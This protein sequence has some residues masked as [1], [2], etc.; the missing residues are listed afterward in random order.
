MLLSGA[1]VDLA[2][3][4]RLFVTGHDIEVKCRKAQEVEVCEVLEVQELE[5][6]KCCKNFRRKA[7]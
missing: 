3:K 1:G 2:R 4:S 5:V 7:K 6:S